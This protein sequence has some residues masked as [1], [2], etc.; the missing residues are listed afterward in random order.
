MWKKFVKQNWYK[1]D[2]EFYNEDLDNVCRVLNCQRSE[3]MIVTSDQD[4]EFVDKVINGICGNFMIH[5]FEG[6]KICSY[7]HEGG[8]ISLFKKK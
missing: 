4:L 6:T 3:V 5:N 8:L 7:Y 1:Q 2:P